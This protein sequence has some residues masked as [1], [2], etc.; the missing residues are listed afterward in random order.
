METPVH[1]TPLCRRCEL[2]DFTAAHP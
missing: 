1:P 2:F